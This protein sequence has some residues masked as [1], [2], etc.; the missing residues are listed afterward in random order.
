MIDA[1]PGGNREHDRIAEKSVGKMI[2]HVGL[3][4]FLPGRRVQPRHLVEDLRTP[5]VVEDA[6]ENRPARAR[7]GGQLEGDQGAVDDNGETG[8]LAD[9]LQ[10]GRPTVASASA[11]SLGRSP[12]VAPVPLGTYCSRSSS[13]I[14]L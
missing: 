7:R 10:E 4:L 6:A 9:V 11:S 13:D 3:V 2:E 8:T 5:G 12:A 14:R 1:R